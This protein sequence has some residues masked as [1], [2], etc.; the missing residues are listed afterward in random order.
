MINDRIFLNIFIKY[1]VVRCLFLF[2]ISL[3]QGFSYADNT[4]VKF[5]VPPGFENMDV[6]KSLGY[7]ISYNGKALPGYVVYDPLQKRL[8]LDEESF[9]KNEQS[10]DN[11]ENIDLILSKINF[12]QC[13]RGCDVE[14]D[15]NNI[16][17]DKVNQTISIND[18]NLNYIIPETKFGLVHNQTIDIRNSTDGYKAANIA[19]NGYVGLPSQMYGYFNWYLNER[20]Y[21]D[22]KYN[23]VGVST[24]YLQK[25][26]SNVY[27]R[28]GKQ[29][30][31]DYYAGSVNSVVTPSYDGFVTIGSQENF[32]NESKNK[33]N[34]RLIFFS[35]TDGSVDIRRDGRTIFNRPVTIGRNEID[36]RILPG[37]YYT[38]EIYY[39]DKNG[40]EINHEVQVIDNVTYGNSGQGNN[41][42]ITAGKEQFTDD[43]MIEFGAGR[44]IFGVYGNL[45]TVAADNGMWTSDININRPLY[46]ND[47]IIQPTLGFRSGERGVGGYTSLSIG[48]DV[49][50]NATASYYQQN[51]IS[52]IY[53][54]VN[55]R[56]LSYSRSFG[57][58]LVSYS[59]GRYSNSDY[60]QIQVSRMFNQNG[61]Y[62]NVS[63]GAKRQ[64]YFG[65]GV[66]LNVSLSLLDSQASIN[67]ANSGNNTVYS[68]NYQKDWVDT[69]GT[70]SSSIDYSHSNNND[71]VGLR[72]TRSGFLGDATASVNIND[73]SAQGSLYYRGSFSAS[74]YGIYPGR[75]NTSGAA[76]LVE[77]PKDE[78]GYY[79]GFSVNG[80]P[81]RSG[82]TLSVPIGNYK[83]IGYAPVAN[84][85]DDIDMQIEVPANIVKS[86]PGQVYYAKAFV[87][88]NQVY[89]GFMRD[90]NGK[91]VNGILDN[92]EPVYQ[93]GLFSFNAK[94]VIN[95]IILKNNEMSYR[96]DLK[97]KNDNSYICTPQ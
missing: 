13:V 49:W 69:L 64:T 3:Y 4:V 95:E 78:S 29:S 79:Y 28:A 45:L 41:W 39:L 22:N 71:N 88:I 21:G 47:I 97:V 57:G 14:I 37:G 50:G 85:A 93:N 92:G 19:G 62:A 61:Y 17:I 25:N 16:S 1:K 6:G 81:V 7:L 42:H 24:F 70:T 74:E 9:L 15:N 82:R 89:S 12:E 30:S 96:C 46:F 20:S 83:T 84:N 10:K 31:L 94:K 91:P 5:N 33:S 90:K 8:V 36:Y 66:F 56:A 34:G 53:Y 60:Q 27:L 59:Y 68:A 75:Y 52:D 51:D 54:T 44:E 18:N 11:I 55:S 32:N 58:N 72:L 65:D 73:Q 67:I 86:H 63:L 76:L 38:I 43:R 80:S 40:R 48:N 26:F 23:D 77:V 87:D 2:N 35:M